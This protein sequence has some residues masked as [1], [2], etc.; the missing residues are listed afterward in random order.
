MSSSTDRAGPG[1]QDHV[2]DRR[3]LVPLARHL[4]A[5]ARRRNV[6]Q[7]L[8]DTYASRCI[9]AR[10]FALMPGLD[11]LPPD[12]QAQQEQVRAVVARLELRLDR[13][14]RARELAAELRWKLS[15]L[16]YRMLAAG[17]GGLRAGDRPVEML[18]SMAPVVEPAAPRPA[19]FASVCRRLAALGGA[20]DHLAERE[21]LVLRL[22]T[23][24]R[25]RIDQ[26][27][28]VLGDSNERTGRLHASAIAKLSKHM[29]AVHPS[30]RPS[31]P[32]E[33]MSAAA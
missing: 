14:P 11:T 8:S 17:A 10:S 20:F 26:V 18:D 27:A 2:V 15:E 31:R 4:L 3:L 16:F 22:V 25:M 12:V 9:G 5:F 32:E 13:A 33:P 29:Q 19:D 28:T 6:A 24:Q 23:K 21:Q 30:A 1:D 7:R